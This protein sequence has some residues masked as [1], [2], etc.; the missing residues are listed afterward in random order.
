MAPDV[1]GASPA[2]TDTTVKCEC[3]NDL[4]PGEQQC[5]WCQQVDLAKDS[6]TAPHIWQ[7]SRF[8]NTTTC[9]VC[10]LLPLD[11]TDAYSD[12]PGPQ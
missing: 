2:T 3:G 8:T 10:G 5:Q 7:T 6:Q 1:H 9:S 11:A 12:C 4:D